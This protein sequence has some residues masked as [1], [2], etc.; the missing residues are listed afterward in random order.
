MNRRSFLTGVIATV[1]APA[2]VMAEWLMPVSVRRNLWT[3]V[4]L[5]PFAPA[6]IMTDGMII[7]NYALTDGERRAIE[8]TMLAHYGVESFAIQ[9]IPIGFYDQSGNGNHLLIP[10]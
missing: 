2:I 1:A 3:L 8:Q 4:D 10:R 7:Y 9:K 5:T 6:E